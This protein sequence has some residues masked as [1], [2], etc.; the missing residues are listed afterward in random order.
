MIGRLKSRKIRFT[1]K[2]NH[3]NK[4]LIFF[5]VYAMNAHAYVCQIRNHS[6][7]LCF[8]LQVKSIKLIFIHLFAQRLGLETNCKTRYEQTYMKTKDIKR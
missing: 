3:T 8:A 1:M 7:T 2:R 6:N 4:L 5:L